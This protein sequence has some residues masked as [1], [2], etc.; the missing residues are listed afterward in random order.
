[1]LLVYTCN[2]GTTVG[3]TDSIVTPVVTSSVSAFLM[4]SG[5][6]FIIGFVCGHCFSQRCKTP[7]KEMLDKNIQPL[8]SHPTPVYEDILPKKSLK[9]AE[10]EVELKDNVAYGPLRSQVH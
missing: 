10:Q 6:I 5:F 9:Q 7:H 3:S 8:Q 4:T 1:M 2:V